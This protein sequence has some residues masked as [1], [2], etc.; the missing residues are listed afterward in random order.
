VFALGLD[1]V[2]ARREL[3]PAGEPL[4]PRWRVLERFSLKR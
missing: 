2:P 4:P 1:R 3:P